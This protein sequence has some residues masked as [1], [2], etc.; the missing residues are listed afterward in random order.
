MRMVTGDSSPEINENGSE[1]WL[2]LPESRLAE[3]T[4]STKLGNVVYC[5]FEDGFP[6]DAIFSL[7]NRH[8]DKIRDHAGLRYLLA[9]IPNV[10]GRLDFARKNQE[11]VREGNELS[12]ILYSINIG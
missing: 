3:I 8:K 5:L 11:V 2:T 10:E 12:E 6:E 4:D 1:A 7:I 9:K